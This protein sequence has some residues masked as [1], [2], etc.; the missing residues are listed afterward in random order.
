M[1]KTLCQVVLMTPQRALSGML[2]I[3]DVRLSEFLND[4][5]QTVL[6]LLDITVSLTEK[7]SQVVA[8][9]SEAAIP[10]QVPALVFEQQAMAARSQ[11]RFY[12]Y[13]QKQEHPA[14][15][16]VDGI[17]IEGHVH[18]VGRLDLQR[19]V[20]V[21]DQLFL[22]VTQ[23]IIS[24][25]FDGHYVLK[26]NAVMVNTAHIQ[27]IALQA[28]SADGSKTRTPSDRESIST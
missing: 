3:G 22:P 27:Y 19:M 15:I 17:E 8:R 14:F 20:S 1:P 11:R 26:P 13:V 12:S 18:T 2:D 25:R 7:P 23:P 9:Y 28:K 16:L 4:R 24:F 21:P 6:T 5:R 10:K